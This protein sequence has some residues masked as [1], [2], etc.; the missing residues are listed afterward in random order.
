MKEIL[1]LGTLVFGAMQALFFAMFVFC[2][3]KRNS[4]NLILASCG[5]AIFDWTIR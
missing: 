1:L 4:P 2:Y 3:R 5:L